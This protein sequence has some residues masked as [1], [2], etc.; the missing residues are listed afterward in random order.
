MIENE[1]K[2][3]NKIKPE[4]TISDGCFL[5]FVLISR[6]HHLITYLMLI[7]TD[8]SHRIFS[9][10]NRISWIN[11]FEQDSLEPNYGMRT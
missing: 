4:S 7:G 9:L 5:N 11:R 6:N 8:T 2:N 3:E 1:I 10:R